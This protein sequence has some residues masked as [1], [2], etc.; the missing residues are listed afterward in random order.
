MNRDQE[1]VKIHKIL[2]LHLESK[3]KFC[4]LLS[5]QAC[6]PQFSAALLLRAVIS[7]HLYLTS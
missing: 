6:M 4:Q 1:R 7:G 5:V 3:N 2:L